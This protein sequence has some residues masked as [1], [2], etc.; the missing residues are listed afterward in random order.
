MA[1]PYISR[2]DVNS[3]YRPKSNVMSPGLQRA[4]APFRFRNALTGGILASF[5]VGVWAYSL[6]AVAQDDFSD[7]DEEA[8]AISASN[9]PTTSPTSN[10]SPSSSNVVSATATPVQSITPAPVEVKSEEASS[11]GGIMS[12]ISGWWWS[13]SK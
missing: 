10:P 12:S 5:A 11:K 2:K 9:P 3:S 6:S 7:V 4:R 1:D 8:K 13:S